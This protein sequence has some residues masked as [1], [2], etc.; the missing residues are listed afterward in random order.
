[1]SDFY[2]RIA[3]AWAFRTGKIAGQVACGRDLSPAKASPARFASYT[4]NAACAEL[5]APFSTIG[6]KPSDFNDSIIFASDPI[7]VSPSCAGAACASFIGLGHG[8]LCNAIYLPTHAGDFIYLP[9]HTGDFIRLIGRARSAIEAHADL[10]E[11]IFPRHD[12][13]SPAHH[14]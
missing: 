7:Y 10:I 1:L 14:P 3:S 5:P 6:A 9:A 12:F 2:H 8:C 11:N 13:L 4:D